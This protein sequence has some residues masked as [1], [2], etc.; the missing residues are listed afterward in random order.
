MQTL[1]QESKEGDRTNIAAELARD[2]R[3]RLACECPEQSTTNRESYYL[4]ATRRRF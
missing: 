4:L 2:W 1:Q 3:S